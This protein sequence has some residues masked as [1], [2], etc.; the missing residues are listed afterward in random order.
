[1]P[2]IPE[3][4]HLYWPDA[5]SPEAAAGADPTRGLLPWSWAV[6][7]LEKSHNYWVGTARPNGRPHLMVV[8]GVWWEDAFWFTTG[9]ETRKARNL[10]ANPHCS[11]ATEE[12]DEAVILEGQAREVT[13]AGAR[14]AFVPIYNAKYEGDIAAMIETTDGSAAPAGSALWRVEPRAVFGLNEHAE[15]FV[16]AATRWTFRL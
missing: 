9:R 14:R 15:D 13:D 10:A 6:E 1:M 11:I 7:R 5:R 16:E 2:S 8:W 3:A 4:S 12:A